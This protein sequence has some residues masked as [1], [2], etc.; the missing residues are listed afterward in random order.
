MKIR[1]ATMDDLEGIVK[2]TKS[3]GY[4]LPQYLITPERLK[5]YFQMKSSV[6]VAVEKGET[7]GYITFLYDFRDGSELHSIEVKKRFHG[8][9]VGK[10][11]LKHAE[12]ETKKLGKNKLY[13][14][15]YHK[16]FGAM[17]F[18]SKNK[19]YV[20]ETVTGHYSGGESA[21]LLVK[22]L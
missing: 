14:I 20:L 10:A 2:V 21:L 4:P 6:F 17:A 22:D 11:L 3:S 7:I 19:F 12:K 5:Q 1:K 9:G 15:V 8:N 13:L 16:N 18:Y